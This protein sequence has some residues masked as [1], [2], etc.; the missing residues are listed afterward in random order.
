MAF[1][2]D[3]RD[4][5]GS[6]KMRVAPWQASGHTKKATGAA[7]SMADVPG[8]ERRCYRRDTTRDTAARADVTARGVANIES[9]SS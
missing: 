2:D 7:A 9:L 8:L 1:D 4:D 5:G 6:D 3:L